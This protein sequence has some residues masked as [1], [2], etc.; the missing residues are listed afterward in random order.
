MT[1]PST[2][3]VHPF[4]L[5]EITV[6]DAGFIQ[7]LTS[8]S[9]WLKHIGDRGTKTLEGALAYIQRAYT[10]PYAVKGYGLWALVESKSQRSIGV[11]GLVSRPD[12]PFPDLGFALLPGYEGHGWIQAASRIVL[13]H[14]KESLKLKTVDAYANE[15]NAR[16][17][18]TLEALG[19][20]CLACAENA[21][22]GAV[23]CHYR[24]K[25]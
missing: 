23:V 3:P 14:A 7:Q 18:K 21:M 24:V 4:R 25:L 9:G 5:R 10:E 15:D 11:C 1:A 8:T 6:M 19:F 17:R 22:F 2:P 16:S 13:A 20:V 12:A